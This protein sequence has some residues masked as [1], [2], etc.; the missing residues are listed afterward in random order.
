MGFLFFLLGLFLGCYVLGW[1]RV[2]ILYLTGKRR[3]AMC[4]RVAGLFIRWDKDLY[5]YEQPGRMKFHSS[6]RLNQ[7]HPTIVMYKRPEKSNE[8]RGL[9]L[10]VIDITLTCAFGLGF[11]VLEFLRAGGTSSYLIRFVSGICAGGFTLFFSLSCQSYRDYHIPEGLR[12]KTREMAE[13]MAAAE[14]PEDIILR[15]FNQ[16]EY[17]AATL[18]DKIFYLL[19]FYR[20]AE[21]KNDLN[22]MAGIVREMTR[23]STVSL[24]DTGKFFLDGELFSYYSFRQKSPQLASQYFVRSR[25]NIEADMDPNGRRRL[26]YY[27]YYIVGDQEA[28]RRFALQ[29]MKALEVD[30]PRIS[31]ITKEYEEKMLRYLLSQI[32]S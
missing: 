7:L 9:A 1:L 31:R 5:D 32:S 21:I 30:D 18:N 29:G 28:A 12:A 25:K 14:K 10:L 6:F 26:A 17:E 13:S 3:G 27:C 8:R 23:V 2:L 24:T 20:A 11:L 15:P 16:Y 4:I 19:S 22:A